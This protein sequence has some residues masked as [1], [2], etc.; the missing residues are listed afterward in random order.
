MK[1][2]ALTTLIIFL[3]F[4]LF[5]QFSNKENPNEPIPNGNEI[6]FAEEVNQT[7]S[8]NFK[9]NLISIDSTKI[10]YSSGSQYATSIK[11]GDILV[12]DYGEG[13]LRKV[14][15]IIN[16]NAQLVMVISTI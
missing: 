11:V 4:F 8:I 7:D 9:D 6:V 14:T 15:N 16:E 13:I 12:S 3:L 5:T 2:K 1:G 10:I